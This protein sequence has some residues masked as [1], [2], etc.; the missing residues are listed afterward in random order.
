MTL[1]DTGVLVEKYINTSYDIVKTVYDNLDCLLLFCASGGTIKAPV[2]VVTTANISLSSL[3][4]VDTVQLVDGD[5]VGVAFQTNAAE[6][7]IYTAVAGTWTRTLDFDNN[8][9]ILLGGLVFSIHTSQFHQIVFT[10]VMDLET[11]L[12]TLPIVTSTVSISGITGELLTYDANG[13][14]SRVAVGTATQVLTSNGVGVEPTFQTAAG[15]YVHPNHSGDVTSVADGATTIGA[16]KVTL[17]MMADGTDGELITYDATGVAAKV[18]VGTATHVLT[19]NGVGAAPTFQDSGVSAAGGE[20]TE[21]AQLN[22]Y[23]G[24]G[25][26]TALTGT[27]VRNFLAG[28]NAGNDI[29]TGDR[30]VFVGDLTGEYVTTGNANVAIGKS[31]LGVGTGSTG[32][33]NN[34]AI[35]AV[36]MGG[37][38][39]LGAI[40]N[41]ALGHSTLGKVTTGNNNTA[42]GPGAGA[43]LTVGDKNI[44]V[45]YLAGPTANQTNQLF[46]ND[47]ESDTPLIHGD[48]AT[49]VVTINGDLVVTGSRGGGSWVQLIDVVPTNTATYDLTWDETLY[50]DIRIVLEDIQCDLD[51]LSFLLRVGS[52]NGGTIYSGAADYDGITRIWEGTGAYSGITTTDGVVLSTQTSNVA[53]ETVSATFE[54]IGSSSANVSCGITTKTL[55]INSSSGNNRLTETKTFLPTIKAAIDTVRLYWGSTGKFQV[56]GTIKVYGLA[57]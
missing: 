48:F 47:A 54:I 9:E 37:T 43:Q 39:L 12:I 5:R 20:F 17:G 34:T 22:L 8:T 35:G 45:G 52:A 33:T 18:A 15:G 36:A 29:T 13:L 11:T 32:A 3:Q 53:N 31:A 55:V 44:C 2:V 25:A 21:D 19:S 23:G 28:A 14:S 49:D 56:A 40:G 41:V 50:S 30:N 26:G 4:I 42:V 24:T 16:K 27:A 1:R 57:R 38:G 46:I 10:G 7:G 51:T 6:N